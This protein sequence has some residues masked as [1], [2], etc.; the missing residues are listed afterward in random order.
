MGFAHKSV[1]LENAGG[2]MPP[3]LQLG[4]DARGLSLRRTL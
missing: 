2:L 4:S 3:G 1:E